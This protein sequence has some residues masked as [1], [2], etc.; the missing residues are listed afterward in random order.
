MV[1]LAFLLVT[2]FMLTSQFRAEEPVIVDTPAS[3]KEIPLPDKDIMLLTV[4]SAGRIFF[5]MDQKDIRIAML[6]EME[7]RYKSTYNI[8]FTEEEKEKFGK[9][10]SFGLPFQYLK[11]YINAEGSDRQKISD[12]FKGI[13]FDTTVALTNELFNWVDAGRRMSFDKYQKGVLRYAIKSDGETN[14][15]KIKK[16]ITM[17]QNDA[18]NVNRF[19]LVT[20]LETGTGAE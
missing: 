16:I 3:N 11:E 13:P 10:G 6:T 17:F 5:S 12:K 15:K 20:S 8:Q 7:N 9:M 18:V 4:D 2:F 1:D 14:Y 19:N